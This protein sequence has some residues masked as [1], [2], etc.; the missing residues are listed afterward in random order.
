MEK[1]HNG[2]L[3]NQKD[4]NR[5]DTSPSGA[6]MDQVARDLVA[7]FGMGTIGAPPVGE[8]EAVTVAG[9]EGVGTMESVARYVRAVRALSAVGA[10][11][12]EL[13]IRATLEQALSEIR[14]G[15]D[16]SAP[17]ARIDALL[18]TARPYLPE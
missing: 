4:M 13:G 3:T 7:A 11:H 8:S 17:L 6:D 2:S 15:G 18:E 10:E 12:P 14:L 5:V 1:R 16:M 9:Q